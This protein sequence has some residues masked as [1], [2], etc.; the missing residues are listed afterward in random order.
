MSLQVQSLQSGSISSSL[1]EA[2]MA[3]V[4]V[5]PLQYSFAKKLNV[6][7]T[8]INKTYLNPIQT[9]TWGSTIGFALPK[10]GLIRALVLKIDVG[11]CLGNATGPRLA[12][13]FGLGAVTSYQL[14]N[15]RGGILETWTSNDIYLWQQL[16]NTNDQAA[17]N[18]ALTGGAITAAGAANAAY[19]TLANKGVAYVSIPFS[20]FQNPATQLDAFSLEDLQLNVT[21][22]G[23]GEGSG[24][25]NWASGNP[26][27]T[28]LSYQTSQSQSQMLQRQAAAFQNNL[29]SMVTVNR[30]SEGPLSVIADGTA[31]FTIQC[32]N[33]VNF[34]YI[35]CK[36]VTAS[37][38]VA[39]MAP[40]LVTV[41]SAGQVLFQTTT[42]EMTL[43]C[44]S[45]KRRG[46]ATLA[47]VIPWADIMQLEEIGTSCDNLGACNFKAMSNLTI[48]V[49]STAATAFTAYCNHSY[50][51]ALQIT[52]SASGLNNAIQIVDNS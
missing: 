13:Q 45:G 50:F 16:T 39:L 37:W 4:G 5:D 15:R 27:L 3:K 23:S 43:P 25:M 30:F 34:S 7:S 40:V 6:G 48:T 22:A 24:V 42:T 31:T 8:G 49:T 44:E 47:C 33:I 18:V 28:L 9:P 29:M 20:T 38:A 36:P 32:K 17:R 35:F 11:A 52:R 19:S 2:L 21:I 10:F 51:Q 26:V 41:T 46:S 14:C 1:N 12:S